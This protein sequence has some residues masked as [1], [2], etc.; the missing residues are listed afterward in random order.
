MTKS[1]VRTQ[2]EERFAFQLQSARVARRDARCNPVP[3]M[4]RSDWKW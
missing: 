2:F 3:T 1:A 4:Y